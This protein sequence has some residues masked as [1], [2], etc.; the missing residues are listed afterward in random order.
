MSLQRKNPV[1]P[2]KY[3]VDMFTRSSKGPMHFELWASQNKSSVT[4]EKSEPIEAAGETKGRWYLFVVTNDVKWPKGFGLPTV[5]KSPENPT[6]P[7]VKE[8]ADTVLRP[9]EQG[10]VDYWTS[11]LSGLKGLVLLAIAAYVLSSR[12]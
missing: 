7:D 4:V 1:P 12:K 9:K 11:E 8:K 6:A 5:V 2:G 10:V 3:W